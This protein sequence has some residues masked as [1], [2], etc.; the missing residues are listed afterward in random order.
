[1]RFEI[2]RHAREEMNR[3]G[4]S[5]VV[6]ECILNKPGQIVSEYGDKKAYQSVLEVEAGKYHLVRI[7]VD[8]MIDPA[9]VVTVYKT[10]KVDKYWRKV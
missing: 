6:V 3:R 10:S 9:R 5:E 4:I 8:D 1:M 7:I 2:S